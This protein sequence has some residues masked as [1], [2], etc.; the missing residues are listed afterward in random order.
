[1]QIIELP[2]TTLEIHDK[3][4]I[5]KTKEG[6]NLCINDHIKVLDTVNQYLTPPYAMILDEINSYSIEFSV[7]M[8]V[9]NDVNIS[10][11]GVVHYR[12]ATK[13]ALTVGQLMIEKPVYFSGKKNNVTDWIKEQIAC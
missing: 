11:I 3:Y 2:F 13:I 4:F 1:M 8:H 10:C 12:L 7:L 5:G 9:R 6:V